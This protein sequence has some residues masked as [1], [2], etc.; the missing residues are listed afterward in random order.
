MVV[1]SVVF[2]LV[3]DGEGCIR[4]WLDLIVDGHS[5]GKVVGKTC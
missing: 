3:V 5:V 4:S 2:T 1:S